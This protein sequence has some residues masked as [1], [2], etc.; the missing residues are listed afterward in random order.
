MIVE[1]TIRV[2]PLELFT[3][4]CEPERGGN[5]P[6]IVMLGGIHED[7]TGPSRLWAELSRRWARAG[8]RCARVDVS[9]MGESSRS[10]TDP[11]VQNFD[12]VWASN[13]LTIG[14]A[15]DPQD[16]TNCVYVGMCSGAFIAIEGALGSRARGL[17]VINPP[18]GIDYIHAI[19]R[20][21]QSSWRHAHTLAR[22]MRR[23][24]DNNPWMG[25][26]MA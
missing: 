10:D 19:T 6:W 13:V 18:L 14:P 5:G 15:L 24:L 23:L 20:L 2:G 12:L 21:D 16:P 22:P 25:A 7:H 11:L 26:D 4:V 1:R 8:L 17:C 9:G 3:I